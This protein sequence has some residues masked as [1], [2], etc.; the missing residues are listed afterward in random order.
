MKKEKKNKLN[1]HRQLVWPNEESDLTYTKVTSHTNK[2]LENRITL[3]ASDFVWFIQEFVAFFAC[4]I[5]G[6]R[7]D[8]YLLQDKKEKKLVRE[9]L[10]QPKES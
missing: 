5:F 10:T 3:V 7:T 6:R 8:D 4:F 9:N 2:P 1:L